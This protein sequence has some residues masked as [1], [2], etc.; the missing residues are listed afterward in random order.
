M[1]PLTP[2]ALRSFLSRNAFHGLP[3]PH[4][5]A[6]QT[7]H[8]AALPQS[9]SAFSSPV[10]P[11]ASPPGHTTAPS[12]S[13]NTPKLCSQMPPTPGLERSQ[14]F[15]PGTDTGM[16]EPSA[17]TH[18][19]ALGSWMSRSSCW[20]IELTFNHPKMSQRGYGQ[21]CRYSPCPGGRKRRQQGGRCLM[22]WSRSQP[23]ILRM[24]R[25]RTA[26]G[27]CRWSSLPRSQ[28]RGRQSGWFMGK[29]SRHKKCKRTRNLMTRSIH[30]GSNKG[31]KTS[32][33]MRSCFLRAN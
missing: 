30:G 24:A 33:V 25:G 4:H 21:S 14:L 17:A 20:I 10:V 22:L 31:V 3:L 7:L 23:V 5:P 9:P 2:A 26:S 27:L 11:S 29:C 28:S 6:V 18:S 8:I 13:Y 1:F 32:L 16:T 12:S 19:P 15:R